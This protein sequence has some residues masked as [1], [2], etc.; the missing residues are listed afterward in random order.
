MPKN[1]TGLSHHFKPKE[2]TLSSTKE[3]FF[4]FPF[5]IKIL[6]FMSSPHNFLCNSKESF[7]VAGQEKSM[8]EHRNDDNKTEK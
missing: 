3:T 1:I 5:V 4:F 6:V 2:T 7:S 8:A